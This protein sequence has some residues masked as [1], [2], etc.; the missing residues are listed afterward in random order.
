MTDDIYPD[1]DYDGFGGGVVSAVEVVIPSTVPVADKPYMVVDDE[2]QLGMEIPDPYEGAVILSP[3]EYVREG[4]TLAPD[5]SPLTPNQIAKPQLFRTGDPKRETSG[6][7]KGAANRI[8]VREIVAN[9]THKNNLS[10]IEVMFYIM[11][12]DDESRAALGL[13]KSDRISANLRAKCASDLLTYMAPKLKS[14]EVKAKGDDDNS[15]G[16]RIFLPANT[17]EQGD[18]KSKPALILPIDGEGVA[19]PFSP[20]IADQ[21][22]Q[23]D[24]D[25][26]EDWMCG[27]EED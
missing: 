24:D 18:V 7:K 13:R 26:L 12:A 25:E 16:V 23:P 4:N 5:G 15:T 6:L 11:N 3:D 9:L 1:D 14:V 17:R 2:G 10:P 22:I 20:E 27:T 21:L 19:I 8:N